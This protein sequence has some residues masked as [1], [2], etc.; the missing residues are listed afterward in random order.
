MV[1]HSLYRDL[2]TGAFNYLEITAK[3][4][5]AIK[6]FFSAEQW[7]L[8]LVILATQEAEVR[9]IVVRSQPGQIVRETLSK[10][11]TKI[12]HHKN[13]AGEVAEGPEIK[14]QYHKKKKKNSFELGTRA[15]A[16]NPSYLG[17]TE[18]GRIAVG[19][20]P[21]QIVREIHL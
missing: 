17:R 16:C 5:E 12:G 9:R 10:P 11:I 7:W 15:Q 2:T 8:T 19:G 1:L 6:T 13:R 21:R 4:K 18:I 3:N 20:Q 14:P